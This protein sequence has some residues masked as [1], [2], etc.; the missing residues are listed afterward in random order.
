MFD[1]HDQDW[2][3]E[4]AVNMEA[5]AEGYSERCPSFQHEHAVHSNFV[6][7][8]SEVAKGLVEG[9]CYRPAIDGKAR[10]QANPNMNSAG[11]PFHPV[12]L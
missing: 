10:L 5:E 12:M 7:A 2:G 11:S 6:E 1:T 8:V 3:L 9:M 4:L